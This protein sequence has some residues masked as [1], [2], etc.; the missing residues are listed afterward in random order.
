MQAIHD[1]LFSPTLDGFDHLQF[2][3][4]VPRSFAGAL[5]VSG[6]VAPLAAF[7][8]RHGD[9]AVIIAHASRIVLG[10][11]F[12]GSCW[13][14]GRC[15]NDVVP[16]VI[17]W[18][19]DGPA[20]EKKNVKASN[21]TE[22]A[23]SSDSD[24]SDEETEAERLRV[25][26]TASRPTFSFPI[27]TPCSWFLLIVSGVFH[28]VYYASRTLP[29]TFALILLNMALG[30]LVQPTKQYHGLAV[31]GAT[32]T[33][34]RGDVFVL[35]APL[36][37]ILAI[38]GRIHL[39]RGLLVGAGSVLAALVLTSLLTRICG[40]VPIDSY[41]WQKPFCRFWPEGIVLLFNT[42]QN[43]SHLW[44]TQP[45]HW[46]LSYA[47]P[48]C[49]LGVL[50]FVLWAVI[51]VAPLRHLSL[52]TVTFIGLYSLLPHKEVRFVLIVF[53]WLIAP[54]AVM[55]ARNAR[56]APPATAKNQ[57]SGVERVWKHSQQ[58]TRE[59]L[60]AAG[61]VVYL[62]LHVA[63]AVGSAWISSHNYPGSTA[64][65]TVHRRLDHPNTTTATDM[66]YTAQPPSGG[67]DYAVAVVQLDAYA[68]MT[69]ISRFSKKHY[70]PS[71]LVKAGVAVASKARRSSSSTAVSLPPRSSSSVLVGYNK[72][73]KWFNRSREE[74][75][76]A[77]PSRPSQQ[78]KR[79]DYHNGFSVMIRRAEETFLHTRS[80][81]YVQ[82]DTVDSMERFDFKKLR[83]AT[84]RF[85]TIWEQP[86]WRKR[87]QQQQNGAKPQ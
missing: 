45:W 50:P 6:I 77:A 48:R 49:F 78:Q 72:N 33:I 69:G 35:V 81:V 36:G 2:S 59:H 56:P 30:Y 70:R 27:L 8:P 79:N 46:Y 21:A 75:T 87:Q 5:V 38:T 43:Q 63:A 4:V 31:L 19:T 37:L 83:I 57:S 17:G 76:A 44:G 40:T 24:D 66:V 71:V 55:L 52:A 54:L 10:L 82:R 64:L 18:R 3:G 23:N 61:M 1:I 25:V 86:H 60:R 34:F 58:T 62:L 67:S 47:L 85:L 29:N 73:P 9:D 65:S 16:T 74:P 84:T 42:V 26:R 7:F 13:F 22:E 68:A 28:I 15:L 12:V 39:F 41:L 32:A 14:A 51:A 80:G 11:L 53:P 20:E